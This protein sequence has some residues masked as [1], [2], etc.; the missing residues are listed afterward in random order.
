M[1]TGL[2]SGGSASDG[3][4]GGAGF[5]SGGTA[6][7]G[8]GFFFSAPSASNASST[9]AAAA[10]NRVICRKP[11]CQDRSAHARSQAPLPHLSLHMRNRVLLQGSDLPRREAEEAREEG[12]GDRGEPR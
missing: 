5:C 3:F 7:D 6:G 1:R 12:D 9:S 8:A 10:R 4:A 2:A 11:P